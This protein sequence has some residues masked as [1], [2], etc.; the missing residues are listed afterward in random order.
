MKKMTK[1][2]KLFLIRDI[3]DW[4]ATSCTA[5]ILIYVLYVL[6][7]NLLLYLKVPAFYITCMFWLFIITYICVIIR[8]LSDILRDYSHYFLE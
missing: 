1:T 8:F 4:I 2:V 6:L 7:S 5:G 3:L